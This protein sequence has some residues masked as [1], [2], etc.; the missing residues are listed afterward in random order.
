MALRR[1]LRLAEVERAKKAEG[2]EDAEEL[3]PTAEASEKS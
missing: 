3:K 2:D 1:K